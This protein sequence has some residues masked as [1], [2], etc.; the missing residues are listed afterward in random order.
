MTHLG[1]LICKE[2][3]LIRIL[4]Y[5]E[6][7]LKNN[8]KDVLRSMTIVEQISSSKESFIQI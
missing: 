5:T 8:P 7:I 6:S 4:I 1:Y 3:L 2:G